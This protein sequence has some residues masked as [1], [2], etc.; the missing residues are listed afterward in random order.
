MN[1]KRIKDTSGSPGKKSPGNKITRGGNLEI[2]GEMIKIEGGHP[3]VGIYFRNRARRDYF[4]KVD[5]DA[6]ILNK[7]DVIIIEVPLDLD[8]MAEWVL[9][10]RTQFNGDGETWADAPWVA[11][12]DAVLRVRPEKYCKRKRPLR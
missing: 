10:I 5:E 2:Y 6:F 11:E 7:G 9:E 12:L 4:V 8:V 1:I 3:T